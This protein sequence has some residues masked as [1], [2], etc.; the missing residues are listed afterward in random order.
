MKEKREYVDELYEKSRKKNYVKQSYFAN[1]NITKDRWFN[2]VKYI[3][4]NE[5]KGQVD[6][7]VGGSPCQ[8]FS[9]VG[10]RRGLEDARG[11]SFS[12]F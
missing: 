5:Y 2:D 1:Y 11:T 6:L 4:G 10:E 8:S 12:P 9:M 7:F 3:D